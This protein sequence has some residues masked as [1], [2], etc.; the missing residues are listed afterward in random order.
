MTTETKV[1]W[2][3]W[4]DEG[5]RIRVLESGM[6]QTELRPGYWLGTVTGPVRALGKALAQMARASA[7][8]AELEAALRPFALFA[9]R[10]D[11]VPM[12]GLDD[13]LYSIHG[14]E[15]APSGKG[16]DL[17]LS[18]CRRARAA[19]LGSAKAEAG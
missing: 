4:I 10:F 6:V 8:V 15:G 9:E 18:N 5:P 11:A 2:E 12:R 14:G 3:G 13:V 7:R 17:R 16:A 19:L 1:V